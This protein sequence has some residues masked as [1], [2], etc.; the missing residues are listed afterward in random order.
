[1]LDDDDMQEK[2]EIKKNNKSH[3]LPPST[4]ILALWYVQ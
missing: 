3:T 4:S 2:K 1:M